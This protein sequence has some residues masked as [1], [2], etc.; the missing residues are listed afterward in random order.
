[1]N[2]KNGNRNDKWSWHSRYKIIVKKTDR[3]KI[4]DAQDGKKFNSTIKIPRHR[5]VIRQA[6]QFEFV[7]FKI[8]WLHFQMIQGSKHS[9]KF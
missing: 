6:P 4:I 1:M 2:K 5:F 7:F 8:K 3:N 9:P